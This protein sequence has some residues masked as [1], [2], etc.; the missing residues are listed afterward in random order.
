MHGQIQRTQGGAMRV[1]TDTNSSDNQRKRLYSTKTK[2]PTSLLKQV[3]KGCL[4]LLLL[5]I[6]KHDKQWR[7][8]LVITF[9]CFSVFKAVYKPGVSLA[10]A[11]LVCY[12]TLVTLYPSTLSSNLLWWWLYNNIK[13]SILGPWPV[14]KKMFTLAAHRILINIFELEPWKTLNGHWWE[15]VWYHS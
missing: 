3:F 2:L 14:I 9:L 1:A 8:F 7:I 10:L 4:F 12:F 5:L 6:K 11:G 15:V 13:Q